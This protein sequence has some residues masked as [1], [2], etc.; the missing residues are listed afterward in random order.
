[1]A[2]CFATQS[3]ALIAAW[4]LNTTHTGRCGNEA[5]SK[6]G[7]SGGKHRDRYHTGFNL[8]KTFYFHM[9]SVTGYFLVAVKSSAVVFSGDNSKGGGSAGER[10]ARFH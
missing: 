9:T 7:Y 10:K 5:L 2:V 8:Y 4:M 1:M 6:T 3:A